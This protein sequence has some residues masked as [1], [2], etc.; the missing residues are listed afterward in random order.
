MIV[1][2]CFINLF[3]VP[4]IGFQ[5]YCKRK[6]IDIQPSFEAVLCYI[7]FLVLNIPVTHFFMV[8]LRCFGIHGGMKSGYYT[9]SAIVS[10]YA[11][12]FASVV[13]SEFITTSLEVAKKNENP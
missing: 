9:L 8:V 6:S 10:T 7:R 1:V 5:L 13:F 12:Y 3:L 11:V 4:C 2:L